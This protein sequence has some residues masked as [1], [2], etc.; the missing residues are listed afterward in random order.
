MNRIA[1]LVEAEVSKFPKEVGHVLASR[2]LRGHRSLAD[3]LGYFA[4]KGRDALS[5]G[6]AR[7]LKSIG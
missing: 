3:R 1:T 2:S 7:C 4:W 6:V 5:S